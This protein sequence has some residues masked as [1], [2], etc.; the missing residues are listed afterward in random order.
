MNRRRQQGEPEQGQGG[1]GQKAAEAAGSA[2]VVPIG[3]R[4]NP[5]ALVPRYRYRG[6]AA[7]RW[8]VLDEM[9]QAAACGILGLAPVPRICKVSRMTDTAISLRPTP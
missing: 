2:C 9:R 6:N 1:A 4:L 5:P 8:P 3:D 7:G